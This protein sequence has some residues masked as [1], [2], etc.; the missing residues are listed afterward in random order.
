MYCAF[1][2]FIESQRYQL[3]SGFV[4]CVLDILIEKFFRPSV[5]STEW[6]I[7]IKLDYPI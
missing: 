4:T 2:I 3:Y 1:Q 7:I 6:D 5:T